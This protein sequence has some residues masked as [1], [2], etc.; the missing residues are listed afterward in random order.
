MTARTL[1][2]TEAAVR[3]LPPVAKPSWRGRMFN[4]AFGIV[5]SPLTP[6]MRDGAASFDI[7]TARP[8]VHRAESLMTFAPRGM[9]V[10]QAACAPVAA[11]WITMPQ[12]EAGRIILF[13]HSGSFIFGRSRLHHALAARIC[14]QAHA[15]ALAVNYSLAPE[16]PFPAAL[17]NLVTAYEWLLAEGI[18]PGQMQILGDSAGGGI[19]LGA[20]IKLRDKGLPMPAAMTLL[21]PWADLTLSGRSLLTNARKASLSN[22][23]E[24]MMICRELYLQGHTPADPL[25]S[26]VFADLSGLP[27][28]LIQVSSS[29][30][31]L[32]DAVRIDEALHRGGTET[33]FRL[34]PPM[35]HGWQ[36][37]G[38][39]LPESR[40]ALTEIAVFIDG[41]FEAATR[42]E[43]SQDQYHV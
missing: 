29:D 11:D 35:P 40:R 25:A 21:A 34:Y 26:P 27:P 16:R 20:L 8:V 36:R 39:L 9:Q 28:A 41:R 14:Q 30:I 4:A 10:E 6:R 3:S 23:I 19:V 12:S 5:G 31:L 42:A 43:R 7:A 13:A 33:E 1:E 18:S 24:M 37:L 2:F 32:D 17:N 15:S 38:A 22:N